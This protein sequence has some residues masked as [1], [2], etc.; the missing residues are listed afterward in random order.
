VLDAALERFLRA[1][2]IENAPADAIIL[3][4]IASD[5]FMQDLLRVQAQAVLA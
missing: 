3:Q 2:K 4:S 5:R 1:V